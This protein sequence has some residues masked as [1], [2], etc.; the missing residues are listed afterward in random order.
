MK[1]TPK[2][3]CEQEYFDLVTKKD[4]EVRWEIE[5]Q[6]SVDTDLLRKHGWTGYVDK[7]AT[8]NGEKIEETENGIP[9]NGKFRK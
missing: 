6:D 2:E 4:T 7:K 9:S 3:A 8:T 5:A 1:N